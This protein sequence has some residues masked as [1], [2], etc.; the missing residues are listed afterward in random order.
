MA[1]IVGMDKVVAMEEVLRVSIICFGQLTNMEAMEEMV[2]TL[3]K[4]QKVD[5]HLFFNQILVMRNLNYANRTEKMGNQEKEVKA[6][7]NEKV[8]Y[9][10]EAVRKGFMELMAT[11]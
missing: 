7:R 6:G 5:L 4:E 11:F 9:K 3:T 1:G 2:E 8:V 10:D